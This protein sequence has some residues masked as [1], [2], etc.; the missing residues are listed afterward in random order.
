M[1]TSSRST[2]LSSKK[3]IESMPRFS[4]AA[5]SR[6]FRA[7]SCQLMR[8]AAKCS[9]RRSMSGMIL[10]RRPWL[11]RDC[12]CCIPP[13]TRRAGRDRESRA[14]NRGR[15]RPDIPTPSF[16]PSTPSS[17]RTPPHSVLSRSTRQHFANDSGERMDE[18][19]P[20]AHHG[21]H[22]VGRKRHAHHQP[23]AFVMPARA[24]MLR[25]QRVVIEQIY[26]PVFAAQRPQSQVDLIDRRELAGFAL[27]FENTQAASGLFKIM[28]HER[29]I[30]ALAE[31]ARTQPAKSRNTRSTA[32]CASASDKSA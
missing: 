9:G 12:S 10:Q 32:A 24:S 6:R 11:R 29:C 17:P 21:K 31:F 5:I 3:A 15:A 13:A 8:N 22:A 7:L 23:F 19:Q 27:R 2:G 25:D 14:E 20:R 26:A 16:R 30:A 28:D 1:R 18:L 4:S